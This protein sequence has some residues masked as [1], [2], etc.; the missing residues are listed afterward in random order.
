MLKF[1][2]TQHNFIYFIDCQFQT[3]KCTVF[4]AW[5]CNNKNVSQVCKFVIRSEDLKVLNKS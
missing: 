3:Y 4:T 5:N 1:K 2:H